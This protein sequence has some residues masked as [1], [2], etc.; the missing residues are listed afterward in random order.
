[1]DDA[2]SMGG[3]QRIGDLTGDGQGVGDRKPPSLEPGAPSRFDRL[4][5]RWALDQLHDEC[6]RALG[7]LDA[8]DRGDVRMIQR[9]QHFRFA[10][11]PGEPIGIGGD[12]RR[13]HLDRDLALQIRIG[14]A[15]D[16]AHAASPEDA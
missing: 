15:V 9:G 14:G 10:A 7:A 13:Q 12:G 2:L 3:V 1:M 11:E 4:P 16:L 6:C 5:Q 8:I